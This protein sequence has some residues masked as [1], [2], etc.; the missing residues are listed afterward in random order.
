MCPDEPDKL[1]T[2][3]PQL[4]RHRGREH[5]FR[6]PMT[7][8]EGRPSRAGEW[9]SKKKGK[10]KA[11]AKELESEEEKDGVG[12]EEEFESEENEGDGDDDE[13]QAMSVDED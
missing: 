7:V 1:Y 3:E 12:D 4:A 6:Q 10:G 2:S 11:T 8:E 5:G 13:S 9:V